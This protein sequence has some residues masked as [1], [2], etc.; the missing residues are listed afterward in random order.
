[1][2]I[3]LVMVVVFVAGIVAGAVAAVIYYRRHVAAVEAAL[4]DAVR[5]REQ[6]RT[7]ARAL[8]DKLGG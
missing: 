2:K 8:R 3:F 5:L 4:A 1:M 7:E 6:A